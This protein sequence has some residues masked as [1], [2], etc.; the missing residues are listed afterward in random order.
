MRQNPSAVKE[1]QIPESGNWGGTGWADLADPH[2]RYLFEIKSVWGMYQG[3]VEAERYQEKAN[4]FCGSGWTLGIFYIP[5][6]FEDPGDP[7]NVLLAATFGAGVILYSWFRRSQDP[8]PAQFK[9]KVEIPEK[10]RK[11]T[12]QNQPQQQ[13]AKPQQQP[14]KPTLVPVPGKQQPK[15]PPVIVPDL[16]PTAANTALDELYTIKLGK[17]TL[18]KLT[19]AVA[20][21]KVFD[22][23]LRLRNRVDLQAGRH[24]AEQKRAAE[25]SVLGAIGF[26]NEVAHNIS[27][28]PASIWTEPRNFLSAARGALESGN[29]KA[30]VQALANAENAYIQCLTTWLTYLEGREEAAARAQKEIPM[31]GIAII[32]V[33]VAPQALGA[34]LELLPAGAAGATQT[35]G[36]VT[37]AAGLVKAFGQ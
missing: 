20:L 10:E 3:V 8:V 28:P 34:L 29:I 23:Y 9:R 16:V 30:A 19:R 4:Q 35:A 6:V 15:K 27:L 2:T 11:S 5:T 25:I 31:I 18:E 14:A 36:A 32:A 12:P 7:D 37:G 21:E 24:E 26:L 13:P 22:Y 17:Q 33:F 1:Y